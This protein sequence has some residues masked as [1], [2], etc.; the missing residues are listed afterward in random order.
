MEGYVRGF[1]RKI[2][3]VNWSVVDESVQVKDCRVEYSLLMSLRRTTLEKIVIA[4]A[5]RKRTYQILESLIACQTER[6]L[7]ENKGSRW[8]TP[9]TAPATQAHLLGMLAL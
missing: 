9:V 7:H 1:R 6:R 4:D 5:T 3:K 2:V 8:M